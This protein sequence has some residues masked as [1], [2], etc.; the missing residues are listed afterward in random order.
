MQPSRSIFVIASLPH[1][2]HSASAMRT[3]VVR[4]GTEV[5][6]IVRDDNFDFHY[7]VNIMA[8]YCT[9]VEEKTAKGPVHYAQ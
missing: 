7:Q 2:H 4:N 6:E 1:A 9:L 8:L 5:A 3:T